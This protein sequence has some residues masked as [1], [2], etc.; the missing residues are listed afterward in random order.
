MHQ[1]T[2]RGNRGGRDEQTNIWDGG[3]KMQPW[4]DMGKILV[5]GL[6]LQKK[7]LK[8]QGCILEQSFVLQ[9]CSQLNKL[10]NSVHNTPAYCSLQA[11]KVYQSRNFH[12]FYLFF[13][14]GGHFGM[15]KVLLT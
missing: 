14:F 5:F 1:N 7:I 10:S 8:N 3:S 4:G 6:I 13:D 9:G 11:V 2:N 15:K 12:F